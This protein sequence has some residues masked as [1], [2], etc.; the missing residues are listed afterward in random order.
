MILLSTT[1]TDL[2]RRIS[3]L[4][5]YCDDWCL[6]V[7]YDKSKVVI[8]NKARNFFDSN[9]TYKQRKLE[10]VRKKKYLGVTCAISGRNICI[11][12]IKTVEKG[13]KGFFKLKSIFGTSIPNVNVAGHIFDH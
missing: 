7:N 9:F 11:C 12:V 6:E 4:E 5:K 10:N 3:K 2:Q 1:E 8:F 13:L